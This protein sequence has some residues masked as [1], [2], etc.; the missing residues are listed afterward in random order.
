MEGRAENLW[1]SVPSPLMTDTF[2][3]AIS[4]GDKSLQHGRS[5]ISEQQVRM[6]NNPGTCAGLSI[7][8][9]GRLRRH[10]IDIFN[11][12]NRFHIVTAR[13]VVKGAAFH[14]DS[15]DNIVAGLNV[16]VELIESVMCC[17]NKRFKKAMAR[18]GKSREKRAQIPQM[19]VRIDNWQ[20]RF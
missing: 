5:S 7:Q 3:A 6:A 4:S 17:G 19:V 14:K 8:P 15:A 2:E 11:L 1:V 9:A 10:A 12:A 16:L 20:V 13:S 18:F